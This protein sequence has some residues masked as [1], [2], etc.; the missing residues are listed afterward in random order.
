ES[1][2]SGVDPP[3]LA[4]LPISRTY[5]NLDRLTSETTTLPEGGTRTVSYTYFANGT[6]QSVTDPDNLATSYTYDG[7][8]RL[9]TATTN[10]G[11]TRYTYWPDDLLKTIE[12]PNGVTAAYGYDQAN[13]LTSL[14]NARGAA[15][16]SSYGYSYDA[17]GNR[18]TQDEA[19]GGLTEHT[20]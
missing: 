3:G 15:V 5:D 13:R 9:A 6:R 11:L 18:L 19:N 14:V 1:V 7:Q 2:A 10:A 4:S 12:Y 8:N 17:N 20:G 16:V